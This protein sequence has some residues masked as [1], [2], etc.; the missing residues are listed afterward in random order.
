MAITI[1][2]AGPDDALFLSWVMLTASRS[3]VSC[4]VWEHFVDGSEDDCLAFLKMM[5]VT[6]IPHLCHHLTFTVAEQDGRP[7]AG[8]C[9]YDPENMGMMAFTQALP[10]V[11][12]KMGWGKEDQEAAFM[13][14]KSFL[15]CMP[16]ETPGSWILENVAA[17]PEVRRQGIISKLLTDMVEK[18]KLKGFKRAQIGVFIG[19]TPARGAYEKCGFRFVDEKRTPEFETDYGDSG[20]ARLIWK[21]N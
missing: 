12:E 15:D 2:E 14:M 16:D 3:H 18:G 20:M 11:F 17:I 8:L 6:R 5:A 10:E 21:F 1:R 19:N 4:G 9:G 7:I 13:R